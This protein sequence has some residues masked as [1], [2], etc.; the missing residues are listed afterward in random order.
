M[1]QSQNIPQQVQ[2]DDLLTI[3]KALALMWRHKKWIALVTILFTIGGV[4]YA[5][6]QEPVYTRSLCGRLSLP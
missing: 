3:L 6:I 2:S 1:N 4:V 5:L